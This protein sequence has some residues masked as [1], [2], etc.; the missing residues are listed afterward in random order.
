MKK[1]LFLSILSITVIISCK[2]KDKEE[3][4]EDP[5]Q[6]KTGI[7]ISDNDPALTITMFS[8]PAYFSGTGYYATYPI[9]INND[10]VYDI[11]III[12]NNYV[13]AS[14]VHTSTYL[15]IRTLSIDC[16]LSTDSIYKSNAYFENT[17]S[18]I[19]TTPVN[20]PYPKVLSVGA[21]IDNSDNWRKGE[22]NLL[23]VGYPSSSTGLDK[24]SYYSGAWRK[25]NPKY[26]GIKYKDSFG[27]I[28]IGVDS[29]ANRICI[30]GFALSK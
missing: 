30:Y 2:K 7:T 6:V 17:D 18:L 23:S 9:D 11:N 28:K 22:F 26:I 13:M 29:D 24:N 12:G 14:S 19:S 25:Q 20:K 3:L 27:W 5:D 4:K 1:I 10:Q 8:S 15:G 16:S 21:T